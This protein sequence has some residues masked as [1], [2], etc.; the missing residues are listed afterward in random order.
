M[1][2]PLHRKNRKIT[3]LK[4]LDNKSLFSFIGVWSCSFSILDLPQNDYS[5][6][7]IYHMNFFTTKMFQ[8]TTKVIPGLHAWHACCSIHS[9]MASGRQTWCLPHPCL[10]GPPNACLEE[11]SKRDT[12]YILLYMWICIYYY[13]LPFGC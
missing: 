6:Y 4:I 11:K 5:A 9:D 8:N 12:T 1:E 2:Y 13:M 3:F 7:C 10:W